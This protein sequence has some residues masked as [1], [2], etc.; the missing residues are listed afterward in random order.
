[1]VAVE[2]SWTATL[3]GSVA[4]EPSGPDHAPV[5]ALGAPREAPDFEENVA[6]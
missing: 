1:M 2:I 4:G 5:R 6:L 3:P